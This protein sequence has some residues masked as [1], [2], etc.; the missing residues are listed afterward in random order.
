LNV[1]I[2]IL[3][4]RLGA[5]AQRSGTFTSSNVTRTVFEACCPRLTSFGPRT[6]PAESA[7]TMNRSGDRRRAPARSTSSPPS[8]R[9]PPLHAVEHIVV[10]DLA[11]AGLDRATSEPAS[12]SVT[13]YPRTTAA[14]S[15]APE[16]PFLRIVRPG[17]RVLRQPVGVDRG[18]DPEQPV[19]ISSV[20]RQWSVTA[21]SRPPYCFGTEV[22]MKPRLNASR[23]MSSG[24]SPERSYFAALGD[25]HSS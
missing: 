25:T 16:A 20:I 8:R 6:I 22:F 15:S 14:R 21:S 17:S 24:N 12:G 3:K 1:S 13:A 23:Q 11:G 4:P 10:A 9:D 7:G 2:A 5:E 18:A 19:A